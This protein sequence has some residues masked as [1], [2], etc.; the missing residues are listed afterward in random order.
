LALKA[1]VEFLQATIDEMKAQ[2][3][4]ALIADRNAL[5]KLEDALAAAKAENAALR[6]ANAALEA[7]MAMMQAQTTS[8][9]ADR[10]SHRGRGAGHAAAPTAPAA[11]AAPDHGIRPRVVRRRRLRRDDEG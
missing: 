2:H 9:T 10:Q 7:Q 3:A 1:Q 6:A 11:V 8:Q 5:A 4:A